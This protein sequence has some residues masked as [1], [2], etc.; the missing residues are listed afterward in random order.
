MN[1]KR[2]KPYVYMTVLTEAVGALAGFLTRDG[3][4]QFEAVPK[5][6]LTPPSIVFP[7]VW[8]ILFFLMAVGAGRIISSPK[9]ENR[10]AALGVFAIQLA[11]NFFWSLFFFNL[12]VYGFS[13]LWL[14]ILWV[15][16]ILMIY[17]F[18]LV[19][20]KA[21]WLQIPYLLWVTFA[22]YLNFAVWRLNG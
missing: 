4:K 12:Q 16:I 7:I 19:D 8:S 2:L 13:L 20:K 18:S 22:A 5:S 17:K 21:A 6:E 1:W 10:T 15:L 3:V 9:S 11:V 14:L